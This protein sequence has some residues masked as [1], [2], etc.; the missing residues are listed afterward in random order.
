MPNI[1]KLALTYRLDNYP[2]HTPLPN[3]RIDSAIWQAF[4]KWQAVSPFTFRKMTT[5]E[6]GMPDIVLR[7]GTVTKPDDTHAEATYQSTHVIIFN[8]KC[9]WLDLADELRAKQI[10]TTVL[11]PVGM[12]VVG[13]IWE[14]IDGLDTNRPD[15]LSVAVHEIGHVLGLAHS[16]APGS[17][18]Q[19]WRAHQPGGY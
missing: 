8:D 15:V 4:A 11:G 1:T 12:I 6:S 10:T 17:V 3:D 7:F 13:G 9:T 5:P 19:P 14:A 18:M 16:S 2:S